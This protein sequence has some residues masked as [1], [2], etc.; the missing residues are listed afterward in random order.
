MKTKLYHCEMMLCAADLMSDKEKSRY[1][2]ATLETLEQCCSDVG[3]ASQT[4]VKH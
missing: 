3:P 1:N 2:P 4:V